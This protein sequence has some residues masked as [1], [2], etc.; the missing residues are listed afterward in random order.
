MIAGNG[1]MTT[2]VTATALGGFASPLTMTCTFLAVASTCTLPNPSFT[3]T[4]ATAQTMAMT[5][6]SQYTLVG[7]GVTGGVMALVL[8][9]AAGTLL[10]G[11][12]V[13]LRLLLM[14]LGLAALGGSLTG[15][16]SKY[17]SLNSPYTEPGEYVYTVT[18][19]DGTITHMATYT[20]TVRQRN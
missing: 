7:Y 2:T 11:R 12:R 3:L 1:T 16:S 10:T 19:T 6:T 8:V 4:G 5:T 9:C 14:M 13:P 18:A 15:C 17:P 20:L